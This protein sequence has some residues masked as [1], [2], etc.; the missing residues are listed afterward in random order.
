MNNGI[1]GSS[2]GDFCE[3]CKS[4]SI[5]TVCQRGYGLNATNGCSPCTTGCAQCSGT[6]QTIC[7]GCS[8]GFT[9]VLT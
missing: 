5:G 4:S 3:N 8:V 1:C 9:S 2:C 7:L 6:F